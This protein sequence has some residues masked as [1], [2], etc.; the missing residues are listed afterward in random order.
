MLDDE[1]TDLPS[2][3]KF[4]CPLVDHVLEQM[5][6]INTSCCNLIVHNK[7]REQ[8]IEII[9]AIDEDIRLASSDIR[10]NM[11]EI[12]IRC[13]DLREWGHSYTKVAEELYLEI[14]PLRELDHITNT[15]PGILRLLYRAIRYRFRCRWQQMFP[16]KPRQSEPKLY[17]E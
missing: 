3:P 9:Q 10:G 13:G 4:G 1:Y 2:E 14:K 15:I 11:E 6:Y 12:R 16:A 7:S 5:S 17:H 8:L